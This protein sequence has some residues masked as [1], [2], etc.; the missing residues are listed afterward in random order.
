MAANKTEESSQS[1]W[2]QSDGVKECVIKQVVDI[3][4]TGELEEALQRLLE[5]LEELCVGGVEHEDL[6]SSF[7]LPRFPL[8]V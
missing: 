4:V 8:L 3:T 7:F 1:P 5:L 2:V 6:P